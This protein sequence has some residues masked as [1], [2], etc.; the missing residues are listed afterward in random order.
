[1]LVFAGLL[2]AV[3][4]IA[5]LFQTL[6]VIVISAAVAAVVAILVHR[7]LSANDTSGETVE[8]ADETDAWIEHLR[9]LVRLNIQ[10]REGGLSG[11]IAGKLEHSID[12]LRELIPQ[13]N[14][15]HVGSELTWT[16]N[17]MATDYLP[18]IVTP[19]VSLDAAARQEHEAELLKSLQG[20]DAELENIVGLLRD[21]KVGEFKTK[22]A[23]LRARFLDGNLG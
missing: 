14:D 7:S 3:L 13:L 22:A 15:E 23:F 16:I 1:L 18:R 21:A 10:I 2:S 19:F 6:T 20:L 17:K 12:V 4:V 11:D 8:A 5:F 9:A